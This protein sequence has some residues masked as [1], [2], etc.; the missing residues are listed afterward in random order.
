MKRFMALVATVVLAT[1]ILTIPAS[2]STTTSHACTNPV[3]VVQGFAELRCFP[4]VPRQDFSSTQRCT[5]SDYWAEGTKT[6]TVD[7]RKY[8]VTQKIREDT[9]VCAQT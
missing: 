7:G 2:A 6:M 3:V 1:G 8:T 5:H 4:E 9:T